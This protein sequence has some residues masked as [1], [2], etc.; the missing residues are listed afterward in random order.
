MRL[1]WQVAGFSV[2]E[3]AH[4]WIRGAR[5]TLSDEAIAPLIADVEQLKVRAI[6]QNVG[7]IVTAYQRGHDPFDR[8]FSR[9]DAEQAIDCLIELISA[10][11]A[12]TPI[13]LSIDE[14]RA[15]A[16]AALDEH[17]PQELGKEE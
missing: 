7:D 6:E 17:P 14:L 11:R 5:H 1:R 10:R 9:Q 8:P 13:A 12:K 16:L 2:C 15:D 3:H 4:N